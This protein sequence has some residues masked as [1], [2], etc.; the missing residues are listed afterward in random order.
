MSDTEVESLNTMSPLTFKEIVENIKDCAIESVENE[1]YIGFST[2]LDVYLNDWNKY[3]TEERIILMELLYN[4]LD[5][6]KPMLAEIAWDLPPLLLPFIDCD[7]PVRFALR[8]SVQIPLF[9]KV[10]NLLA[11]YGNPKELLL[12]CCELL[13]NLKDAKIENVEES[14]ILKVETS[15]D[16]SYKLQFD[17]LDSLVVGYLSSKS[18]RCVFVKFHALFQCI[19]FCNQ[20]IKTIYPSKF[21]SMIIS[22]ILNFFSSADIIAGG[23][24]VQ[25]SIY[26]FIRDYVP[27]DI[28]DDLMKNNEITVDELNK[29]FDDECYLQRKLMRLLFDS[30]VDKLIR[31]HYNA[32]VGKLLPKLAVTDLEIGEDYFE[33]AN[34]LLSLAL[35]LDINISNAFAKEIKL[36]A[37]LLDSNIDSIKSSEDILVLVINNYNNSSFRSKNPTSLP[38]STSSLCF[39]YTFSKYIEKWEIN[40][41]EEITVLDLIKCQL[42]LFIPYIVN[43]ALADYTTLSYFMVLTI[44]KIETNK[45]IVSKNEFQDEKI[46][47]IIFTY[48]QNISSINCKSDVQIV[49]KLFARFLIKFLQ[50]LPEDV[51]YSYIYDTLKSCPFDENVL[52]VL[53]IFKNL[54]TTSK[55]DDEKLTDHLSKMKIKDNEKDNNNIDDNNSKITPPTL[56]KRN[57]YSKSSFINFSKSKQEDFINLIN[58]WI[59]VTFDKNEPHKISILKS[60]RLLSYLNFINSV[61]FEETEKILLI[62]DKIGKSVELVESSIDENTEQSIPVVID[63]IKFS[64]NNAKSF[65]SKK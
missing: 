53:K 13:S 31:S 45:C 23:L 7:W 63:L 58:D 10:F 8:D 26:L 59:V 20:R 61:R 5:E 38:I 34:R 25:R 41:P 40:L 65:Y 50:H 15:L 54:I 42:K 9:W 47:L 16:D 2:I 30:L 62:L 43:S 28:P 56:P 29:I 21:L 11:E 33:L 12:T 22:S 46:K 49:S 24:P 3:N 19:K 52:S 18:S 51:S 60:N 48:L 4:I 1:D 27:P 44:L 32:Y 36:A 64:V 14:E 57:S 6:N 37:S 17:D 35:S 55:F 39:L